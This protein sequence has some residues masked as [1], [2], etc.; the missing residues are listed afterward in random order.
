MLFI[1]SLYIREIASEYTDITFKP[2]HFSRYYHMSTIDTRGSTG[3]SDVTK[4]ANKPTTQ[5]KS[6]SV[7]GSSLDDLFQAHPIGSIDK[8]IG[9]NLWGVNHRQI[10]N[11]VPSNRDMYGL[12]FFTRPQLNLQSDNLRNL[13]IMYPL[14]NSESISIHRFIR[15]TLDP[16]LMAGYIFKQVN[17]PPT[18]CPL[19]DNKMAFIPIL[20]NNL[21]NISGWPDMALTPFTSK[22]GLYKEAYSLV[23]D[24]VR[25]F[26]SFTLDA[27][28]RNT[29]GDPIVFMFYVWLNYMSAVFEGTLLPYLDF[30]TEN[31]IDYNTRIYR[32]VLD[33]NK[34]VVTKIAATG[35]AFPVSVPMGSFF[36]FNKDK[37]FNDQNHDITIRF[38][39]M[40]VDYQDDILIKEFN[41]TVCIFNPAMADKI[42]ESSQSSLIKVDKSLLNLFNN[43]GYPRINPDTRVL[44]WW[45]DSGTFDIRTTAF[46]NSGLMGPDINSGVESPGT[47][48]TIQKTEVNPGTSSTDNVTMEE[49][50]E[51]DS[52]GT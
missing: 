43:R 50:Q 14:L 40:G 9:N 26:Q 37:P 18:K 20:T 17:I 48:G 38:Q 21:N 35:A 19:T 46:L 27:S 12:T 25:N 39:C 22:P 16:R 36:D 28:F 30:I 47:A 24:V 41:Q 5:S 44:E 31:E 10:P 8:A 11:A 29:R 33:Q 13:R 45:V 7:L 23:D 34:E 2:S 6:S 32:L 1:K 4:P 42:R 3:A 51:S 52:L 49:E 15:T